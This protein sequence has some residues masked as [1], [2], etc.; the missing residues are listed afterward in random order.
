MN[1]KNEIHINNDQDYHVKEDNDIEKK[2]SFDTD[3]KVSNENSDKVNNETETN[4][5]DPETSDNENKSQFLINENAHS[6]VPRQTTEKLSKEN[7][8]E[9]LG[10]NLLPKTYN[11]FSNEMLDYDNQAESIVIDSGFNNK[12]K[13]SKSDDNFKEIKGLVEENSKKISGFIV[14]LKKQMIDSTVPVTVDHCDNA[15]KNPKSY[16]CH[17][18][19]F[20]L[21]EEIKEENICDNEDKVSVH[22]I[23]DNQM[24]SEVEEIVIK[25]Q[26]QL[27]SRQSTV[28]V[29]LDHD[30]CLTDEI[31]EHVNNIESVNFDTDYSKTKNPMVQKSAGPDSF[32]IENFCFEYTKESHK[33][34]ESNEAL[35]KRYDGFNS[36]KSFGKSVSSSENVNKTD[37]VNNNKLQERLLVVYA[38][39]KMV[40]EAIKQEATQ[41][42][43]I[44]AF[45]EYG[46]TCD[47]NGY[48]P[49]QLLNLFRFSILNLKK[50]CNNFF[51]MNPHLIPQSAKKDSI[52][53]GYKIPDPQDFKFN[54]EKN[55]IE[56][57]TQPISLDTC[58]KLNT[59]VEL[60]N[61]IASTKERI[62]VELETIQENQILNES[63]KDA[64]EDIKL[65]FVNPVDA[66][67]AKLLNSLS[68]NFS[69]DFFSL[70]PDK[71]LSEYEKSRNVSKDNIL[72]KYDS[73]DVKKYIGE[74]KILGD[75]NLAITED[76]VTPK[77]Q[78]IPE[79]VEKRLKYTKTIDYTR[80]NK[81]LPETGKVHGNNS[82]DFKKTK[83][84]NILDNN[85]QITQNKANL[86]H[87]NSDIM[88][89][90]EKNTE[91]KGIISVLVKNGSIMMK[92]LQGVENQLK[93]QSIK[94][95]EIYNKSQKNT[96][97]SIN[98]SPIRYR[99]T[100]NRNTNSE[101]LEEENWQK[102][103]SEN[104]INPGDKFKKREEKSKEV[105][106]KNES[107]IKNTPRF[108]HQIPVQKSNIVIENKDQI[109]LLKRFKLK[110]VKYIEQIQKL[111]NHIQKLTEELPNYSKNKETFQKINTSA[112]DETLA[113]K[114]P[115][116]PKPQKHKFECENEALK[117]Q[118]RFLNT[119]LL[120]LSRT[121]KNTDIKLIEVESQLLD[122]N[123]DSTYIKSLENEVA[124][125]KRRLSERTNKIVKN[126]ELS[127]D[128]ENMHTK[129]HTH[130]PDR[131]LKYYS[132]NIDKFNRTEQRY[133][134]TSK[135]HELTK[136]ESKRDLITKPESKRDLIT[137]PESKRDFITKN[138]SKRDFI[139][140]TEFYPKHFYETEV[141]YYKK[142]NNIP[143]TPKL[144]PTKAT[145]LINND[146]PIRSSGSQKHLSDMK[147]FSSFDDNKYDFIRKVKNQ[148]ILRNTLNTT[149]NAV[150]GKY[151]SKPYSYRNNYFSTEASTTKHEE[152]E[153][154]KNDDIFDKS[155]HT[156]KFEQNLKKYSMNGQKYT[157]LIKIKKFNYA[158]RIENI[159]TKYSEK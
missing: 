122:A 8:S 4:P 95:D 127:I 16:F 12:M 145:S 155:K 108:D 68:L 66:H 157:D 133:H 87:P 151:E 42:Y 88:A 118:I 120:E 89:T 106:L 154:N 84:N 53:S 71:I 136:P 149:M 54:L 104:Y 36:F 10:N 112:T 158:S 1:N 61:K 124:D 6:P 123:Y 130:S 142:E 52:N 97:S 35:N 17:E 119:E 86:I 153:T 37:F 63:D 44:K 29:R 98:P 134:L 80:S 137:K 21:N 99:Q 67:R 65:A 94:M 22:T 100:T 24:S 132:A 77:S 159:K 152:V 79:N 57:Q 30:K 20:T 46:I 28:S 76:N 156:N 60:K 90:E 115:N 150:S 81:I 113:T 26:S 129:T 92:K 73:I 50:P 13:Q 107:L 14:E 135:R 143:L 110:E 78:S 31:D 27:K 48:D 82:A 59:C 11:N 2:K 5:K 144:S 139:T 96:S 64:V 9:N 103:I 41:D 7:K 56:N 116:E 72:C 38:L 109:E 146:Y 141:P 126:K 85:N 111:S 33:K 43:F 91:L 74:N 140:K 138:E 121:F 93:D 49:E 114:A 117:L 25:S 15:K 101:I 69:E 148:D 3:L 45:S 34:T 18:N 105:T 70:K 58:N 125:L 75:K 55:L 19:K 32:N 131:T 23:S 128:F 102:V 47:T 51:E 62:S 147:I 83:S 39:K 40:D